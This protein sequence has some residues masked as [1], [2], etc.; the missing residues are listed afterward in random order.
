MA[1]ASKN[2]WNQYTRNKPIEIKLKKRLLEIAKDEGIRVKALVRDEFEKTIRFEM[3]KSYVPATERGKTVEEY[4]S[5]HKF[6]KPRPYH[7]TGLLI[8]NT[9]ARMDDDSIKIVITSE[10]YDDGSSTEEVYDYLKLQKNLKMIHIVTREVLNFQNIF[11]K[12]HIILKL[13]LT[14][15]WMSF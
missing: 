11:H 15:I 8:R 7:H 10:K 14:S 2:K 12:L 3:Y 5:T 13:V 1:K 4:N 6:S 9:H